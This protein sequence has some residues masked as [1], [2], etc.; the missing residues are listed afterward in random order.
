MISISYGLDHGI[1]E[2]H[3]VY[4]TPLQDPRPST[5]VMDCRHT[6]RVAAYQ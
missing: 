5:L 1:I 3:A 4:V 6:D 2:L